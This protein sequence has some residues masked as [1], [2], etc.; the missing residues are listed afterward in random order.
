MQ[1]V[2]FVIDELIPEHEFEH[3][4]MDYNNLPATRY[5]DIL[6]VIKEAKERIELELKK[7]KD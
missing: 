1:T 7:G 4:L 3:T 5:K 6:F 2:R